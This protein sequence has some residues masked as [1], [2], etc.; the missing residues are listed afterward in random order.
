MKNVRLLAEYCKRT[1]EFHKLPITTK[2]FGSPEDIAADSNVELV[3]IA[4][5]VRKHHF[6][7]M[8]V[9]RHKKSVFVEWPLGADT[10]QAEEMT[11]LAAENEVKTMVGLQGR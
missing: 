10:A 5:E 2:A 11:K 3:I 1:I 4:V 9:L 6:L 8:P 7:A